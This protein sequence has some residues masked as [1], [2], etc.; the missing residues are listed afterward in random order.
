MF[1]LKE[2]VVTGLVDG[3]KQGSF[4]MPHITTMAAN[5]IV[6]GI[7][8]TQDAAEIAA[9]CQAWDE[10]QALT[11]QQPEEIDPGF[12]QPSTPEEVEENEQA[13]ENEYEKE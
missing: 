3:Y 10:Q 13:E 8:T 5:Y 6:A 12:T 1:N 2:W 7:L 9:Q 4:S 11:E